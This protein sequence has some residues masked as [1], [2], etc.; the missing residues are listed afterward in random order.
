MTKPITATQATVLQL[1]TNLTRWRL[2]YTSPTPLLPVSF[3]ASN[4]ASRRLAKA[5]LRREA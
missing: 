3:L 2:L 5:R 4:S 1:S